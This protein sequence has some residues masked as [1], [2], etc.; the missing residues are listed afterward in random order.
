M[1]FTMTGWD[2]LAVDT[3][4]FSN[5]KNTLFYTEHLTGYTSIFEAEHKY[6][7]TSAY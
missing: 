5:V 4:P 7:S 1:Y 2:V 6:G 3:K